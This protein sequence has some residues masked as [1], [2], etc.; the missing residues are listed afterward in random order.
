METIVFSTKHKAVFEAV[1][2]ISKNNTPFPD[3]W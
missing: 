2:Q 1:I 3:I